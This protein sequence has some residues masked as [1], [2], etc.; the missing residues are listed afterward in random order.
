MST[1]TKPQLGGLIVTPF[2]TIGV[3]AAVLVWEVE[4]VSSILLAAA[5]TAAGVAIGIMVARHLRR[6]QSAQLV[7]GQRQ[8]LRRGLMVA[9]PDSVQDAGQLIHRQ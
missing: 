3:L 2:A 5:L 7:V 6:G 1:H 9:L 8:Q 4:H